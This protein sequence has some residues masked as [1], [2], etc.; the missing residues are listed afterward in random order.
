VPV[1]AIKDKTSIA[2][3]GWTAFTKAS[4]TSVANLAAEASLNAIADAGLTP[5]DIDGIVTYY[6]GSDSFDVR[7][8]APILGLDHC[9]FDF[10]VGLGGGWACGAI[11]TAAM[12][13]FSGA[14][15]NVL[16]YRAM[17][18]RSERRP[19]DPGANAARG[20]K[21]WTVPVG[22]NH[23]ADVFGLPVVAHMA[24]YGTSTVD[25]AHLAVTQRRH[26][27]LNR[28]A[29]MRAPITVEEHQASPYITYPFRLLDCCLQTDGAAAV[30]VTSTER[31]RSLRH[32]PVYIS[33][34]MGGAVAGEHPWEVNAHKAAPRL[35]AGAGITARD[36][37][38]AELYD[39]FTGMCLL[40]MEG[41]GLAERGEVGAWVRAG[42]N[43]LDG[44]TPVNTHGGLHSEAYIQGL[45]HVVEAVQQLRPGGVVD[46]FCDGPHDYDRTHCRQ[47]R[48]PQVALVC[49]ECGDTS[50]VLSRNGT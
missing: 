49:G 1:Q 48:D 17:N 32:A 7:E 18:G 36:V 23:A 15:T 37:D 24:R 4:G 46:D 26:A 31:A 29:M 40:H 25:F 5:K 8:M 27:G 6:Y 16:V 11:A 12:A 43:G 28:K 33:G 21:Q 34:I 10:F 20:P 47:V 13:V 45:N 22:T 44:E 30:V 38:F 3:I 19:R 42:N 2:G 9:N 41:F 35:Y 50:L 14:C 39:P